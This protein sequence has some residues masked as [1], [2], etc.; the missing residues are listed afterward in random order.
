MLSVLLLGGC[1]ST[2]APEFNW[3][4]PDGGEYLFAFDSSECEAQVLAQGRTLGSEVD[5]PF[6]QCMQTRGYL[7]VSSRLRT[8]ATSPIGEDGVTFNE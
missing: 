3:Y 7:L 2:P 6:F 4:H 8:V 5:G 1:T